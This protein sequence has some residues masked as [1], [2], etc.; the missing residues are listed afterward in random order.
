MFILGATGSPS[1]AFP[2]AY[3]DTDEP[4][5]RSLVRTALCALSVAGVGYL[6]SV[7]LALSLFWTQYSPISQFASDYGVGAFGPEMNAGFFLAG[8]GVVSLALVAPSGPGSNHRA[9]AFLLFLDGLCLVASAFFQTD[10]EGAA[11]TFHGGVHNFAGVVFFITSPVAVMLL[12]RRFGSRW[13]FIAL[14]AVA[15]AVAFVVANGVLGLGATGLAERMVILVVFS[16]LI[17]T[18]VRLLSDPGPL[19]PGS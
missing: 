11:A 2:N 17:L 1:L 3:I 18:S 13:F 16:G 9:A 6:G 5:K 7:I 12:G 19:R 10:I 8:A 15:G 4:P 14:A